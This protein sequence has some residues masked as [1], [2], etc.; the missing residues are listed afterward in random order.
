MS[1]IEINNKVT[2][3][4]IITLLA[5]GYNT[6]DIIC[7]YKLEEDVL[8]EC[9]DL[10]LLDK[11]III[12]GINLSED[13]LVKAIESEL[14]TKEDIKN[15][16]MS[17]YSTLSNDFITN[18]SDYINWSKMILYI[19]TQSD[20]FD[21]YI[22]IIEKNNLWD[23]ISAND[24][25]LDFI[26]QWKDK[27]S[28]TYLSMVKE[29]SDEEKEEFVDYIVIPASEVPE[30]EFIDKSQFGFVEKMSQE[31]LEQLIEEINKHLYK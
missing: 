14:F 31:E 4:W 18:Y 3:D 19:S 24:L 26:R 27:L 11:E 1:Q 17:T 21:V 30:G 2:K 22:D 16:T 12:Q 9:L 29:F 6:Y 10:D 8:L 23:S 25:P 15:L 5:E 13:F 7:N 28:W 20:T